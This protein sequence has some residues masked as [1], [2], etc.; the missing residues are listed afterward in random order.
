MYIYDDDLPIAVASL[1][2]RS[3]NFIFVAV[4]VKNNTKITGDDTLHT[5]SSALRKHY[6]SHIFSQIHLPLSERNGN[7]R[8][9]DVSVKYASGLHDKNKTLKMVLVHGY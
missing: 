5:K 9:L 6:T 3:P 8:R 2:S 7:A 1:K 4:I